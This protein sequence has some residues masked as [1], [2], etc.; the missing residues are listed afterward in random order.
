MLPAAETVVLKRVTL[1][2][3]TD[4]IDAARAPLK[5]ALEQTSWP[6]TAP[7][8]MLLLRRITTRGNPREI[9]AQAAEQARRLAENAVDGW[10]AGASN[11]LAVRFRNHGS[12]LACL[13]RD[14]LQG[15]A[16]RQWYWGRW[17]H[18]LQCPR[19]AAIVTLLEEKPL[20]LPAVIMQLRHT[21]VWQLFWQTLGSAGAERLLMVTAQA[22]GWSA[23]VQKARTFIASGETE[24]ETSASIAVGMLP[25]VDLGFLRAPAAD[26]RLMLAALMALWQHAP[27]SLNQ[28]GGSALLQRLARIISREAAA[29]PGSH[30]P[31]RPEIDKTS[32][33]TDISECSAAPK[34]RA[35]DGQRY[36]QPGRIPPAQPA[37]NTEATPPFPTHWHGE[38]EPIRSIQAASIE[39]EIESASGIDDYRDSLTQNCIIEQGGMFYLLNFLKLPTVQAQLPVGVPGAGWRWLHDLA[40]TLGCPPE[41]TLL[42]FLARQCGLTNGT[43][44]AQQAP[45]VDMV[46]LLRLGAKR[47]GDEVWH[48]DT[49]RIPARLLASA[50]HVDLHFSLNDA[51]LAVRRV[52][53]DIN[54]GWLPW[55]GRVVTF[56]YGSGLEPHR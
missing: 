12:L 49:F 11:A 41:G 42:E 46:S 33:Q 45:Q 31:S 21:P 16:T 5:T 15:K 26:S 44:L 3:E 2:G 43:E 20:H 37:V 7:D 10:S 30:Q 48:P 13:V 40:A 50:S 39:N 28:P 47:Y 23:A 32:E 35:Q 17:Q 22:T 18:I 1:H 8:E 6:A 56:H 53:L 51:S 4:A 29:T 36:K 9:A 34:K 27:A 14:L 52:G 19:G 24:N 55:F 54:P 38:N 25:T